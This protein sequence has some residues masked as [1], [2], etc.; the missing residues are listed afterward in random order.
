MSLLLL[1]P[2]AGNYVPDLGRTPMAAKDPSLQNVAQSAG[3]E[4]NPGDKPYDP[5]QQKEK[6][7]WF[8]WS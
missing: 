6:K 1:C 3:Y 8:P 5:N 4:N 7:G 2:T